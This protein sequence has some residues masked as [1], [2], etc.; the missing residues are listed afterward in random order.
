VKVGDLVK[1]NEPHTVDLD[2]KGLLGI[3]VEEHGPAA[4]KVP[5]VKVVWPHRQGAYRVRF[6][7]VISE[8]R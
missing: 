7:E 5:W 8:S 3:V 4:G 2:D 1:S 6:L